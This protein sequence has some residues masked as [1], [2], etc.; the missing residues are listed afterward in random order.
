MVEVLAQVRKWGRSLGVVIPQDAT[1]KE[2]LKEGSKVKLV[3]SKP[4]NPFRES[5]G[6]LRMKKPTKQLLREIRR[7]GWDE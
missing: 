3:I 5:F 2:G 6:A 1:R 4:G 7:E